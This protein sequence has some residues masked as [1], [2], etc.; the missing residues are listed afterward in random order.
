[1]KCMF[2]QIESAYCEAL[3]LSKITI[4]R[5]KLK[6]KLLVWVNCEKQNDSLKMS[7]SGSFISAAL[8]Y[9]SLSTRI[10]KLCQALSRLFCCRLRLCSWWPLPCC[11]RSGGSGLRALSP[12][13]SCRWRLAWLGPC[14]S[15]GSASTQ[16]RCGG[17][18]QRFLGLRTL[19]SFPARVIT[20]MDKHME[21]KPQLQPNI[22]FMKTF[23]CFLFLQGFLL[24]GKWVVGTQLEN[25]GFIRIN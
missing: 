8:P 19:F 20:S 6:C 25:R 18:S 15:S 1:M 14:R 9:F 5:S 22:H 2:V 16:P 10:F 24:I 4:T 7:I 13:A 3:N 17:L 12:F 21:L 23:I 11:P